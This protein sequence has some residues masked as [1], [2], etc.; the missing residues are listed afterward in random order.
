MAP[1]PHSRPIAIFGNEDHACLFEHR[2]YA[3][4]IVMGWGPSAFFEVA[5]GR[6]PEMGCFG[7]ILLGPVEEG[8]RCA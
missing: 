1:Q 7:E 5:D 8:S 3:Q 6:Q 4:K 2:S